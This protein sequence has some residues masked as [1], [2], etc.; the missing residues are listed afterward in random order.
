MFERSD[1]LGQKSN[2]KFSLPR[3]ATSG[4]YHE[5]S[6]GQLIRYNEL[7]PREVPQCETRCTQLKRMIVGY[8][9][10]AVTG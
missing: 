3:E 7:L 5:Q 2:G 10:F 4:R 1:I 9:E 6:V 8:K